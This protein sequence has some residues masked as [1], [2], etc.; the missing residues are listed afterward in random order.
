MK[1]NCDSCKKD[2]EINMKKQT[3]IN[4]CV[5]E[6]YRT[7]TINYFECIHCNRRYNVAYDNKRTKQLKA[8]VRFY[9][10]TRQLEMR[11]NYK[12]LLKL[13]TAKIVDYVRGRGG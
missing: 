7:I 5:D 8:M 9:N 10:E 4:H 11:D 6:V 2:F 3:V 13:E 1:V 12:N